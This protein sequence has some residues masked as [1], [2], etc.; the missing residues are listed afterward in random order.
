M[1]LHLCKFH[2]KGDSHP[3]SQS[4]MRVETYLHVTFVCKKDASGKPDALFR[5]H[6]WRVIL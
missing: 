1:L 3:P 4:P 5:L 6:L 2:V